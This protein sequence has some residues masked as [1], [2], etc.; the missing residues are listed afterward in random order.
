M[1]ASAT[2]KIKTCLDLFF[3]FG[4][5]LACCRT[6]SFSKKVTPNG[7][8][9]ADCRTLL[10]FSSL[11]GVAREKKCAERALKKDPHYKTW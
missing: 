6:L 9:P 2:T 10:D 7:H 3:M 11:A 5:A 8:S 1:C 4:R